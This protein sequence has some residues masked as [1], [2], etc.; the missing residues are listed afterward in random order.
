MTLPFDRVLLELPTG[1]EILPVSRFMALPLHER[2]RH[3]LQREVEFFFG[4]APVDRRV[5]LR[6]LMQGTAP[7]RT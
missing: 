3:V 6:A 7:A 1:K 4:H 2:V 5:A